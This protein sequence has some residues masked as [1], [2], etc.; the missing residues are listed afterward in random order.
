[1]NS[2]MNKYAVGHCCCGNV[3]SAVHE[4]VE[5]RV[6]FRI[7]HSQHDMVYKGS[8]DAAQALHMRPGWLVQQHQKELAHKVLWLV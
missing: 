4:S 2:A 6:S 3:G 7:E 1:M 5:W 8:V